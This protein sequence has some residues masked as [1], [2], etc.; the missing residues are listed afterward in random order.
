M[1]TWEDVIAE[2]ARWPNDHMYLTITRPIGQRISTV[3]R[4]AGRRGP[5]GRVCTCR[6]TDDGRMAVTA[7]FDKDQVAKFAKAESNA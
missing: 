7:V 1:E 4:L 2:C 3:I 5:M 6:E